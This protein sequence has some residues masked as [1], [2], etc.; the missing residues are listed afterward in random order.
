MEEYRSSIVNG[1]HYGCKLHQSERGARLITTV[2][3]S[4]DNLDLVCRE[5]YNSY[6]RAS[7]WLAE[8]KG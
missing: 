2:S 7:T 1:Q 6:S 5:E 4:P 8:L 3:I